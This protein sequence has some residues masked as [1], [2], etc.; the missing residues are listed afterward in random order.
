MMKRALWASTGYVLGLGSS[1][2]VQRRVRRTI[3]RYTPE[4]MHRQLVDRSR[5]L[6]DRAR[7]TVVD[8]REAATEGRAA[9]RESEIE[10]HAEFGDRRPPHR[11]QT[12][13]RARAGQAGTGQARSRS[14]QA[15]SAGPDH[16]PLRPR[17]R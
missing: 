1:I 4:Q 15:R 16:A 13:S 7:Q 3:G 14:G 6:T 10:L 2:W 8:L 5:D 17:R 11:E 12:R 9:M